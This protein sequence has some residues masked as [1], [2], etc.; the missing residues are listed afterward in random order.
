M[1]KR[2]CT[3]EKPGYAARLIGYLSFGMLAAGA[4][5][6]FGETWGRVW[7]GFGLFGLVSSLGLNSLSRARARS[8]YLKKKEE[9]SLQA[10]K[11]LT[12]MAI[13]EESFDEICEAVR[14]IQSDAM[15]SKAKGGKSERE[16]RSSLNKPVTITPLEWSRTIKDKSIEGYMRNIS[17]HGFGLAHDCS[18]Q[19]GYVLLELELENRETVGFI[20]DLLW[21]EAQPNGQFFSGGKFLELVSSVAV[22]AENA[23]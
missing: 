8:K 5:A 11:H 13:V 18:L 4:G 20:A 19:Q 12:E 2:Q 21:C 9:L 15:E 22:G 17:G 1:S 7:F 16:T 14:R 3:V 6:M 10:E 23:V